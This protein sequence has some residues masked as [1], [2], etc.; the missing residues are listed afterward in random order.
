ALGELLAVDGQDHAVRAGGRLAGAAETATAAESAA[1]TLA[2]AT[3]AGLFGA[4]LFRA[5]LFCT[6]LTLFAGLPLA[7]GATATTATAAA[8]G[9]FTFAAALTAGL[10]CFGRSGAPAAKSAWAGLAAADGHTPG[11]AVQPRVTGPVELA[12]DR[13]VDV[14]DADRHLLRLLLERV[15]NLRPRRR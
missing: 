7:A 14:H 3:G 5:G 9:G 6:G 12:H 4:G 1:A 8:F 13:A 2:H 10:T 11:D 15:I